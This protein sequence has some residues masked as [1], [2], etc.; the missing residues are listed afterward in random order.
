MGDR[1]AFLVAASLALSVLLSVPSAAQPAAMV[2]DIATSG[3]NR[4]VPFFPPT[5]VRWG[6]SLFFFAD[7]GVHGQELWASDGTAEGTRMVLDICPG[8]CLSGFSSP[9]TVHDGALYF[10]ANDGLHGRELWR[11]D[12]TADGT[13]MV[14]DGVPGTASSSPE[15]LT[16]CGSALLFVAGDPEHGRELWASDGTA[17]GT[18]LLADI[19]PAGSSRPGGF[20]VWNGVAYFSADDG[21]HGR[22]PWRT[23]GTAAGTWMVRDIHAGFAG[24]VS[25]DLSYVDDFYL[26]AAL[27]GALLFAAD[28][29]VHGTELW[30]SDGTEGGTELV[31][32]LVPG[33]SSDSSSPNELTRLGDAVYFAAD[34]SLGRELWASDGTASGTHLVRD[35]APGAASARPFRFVVAGDRLFFAATTDALG[36]ELWTSDGTSAGTVLVEDLAPGPDGGLALSAVGGLNAFGDRVLMTARDP[37]HGKEPWVS[38]GTPGGTFRLADL[39]AGAAGAFDG[40]FHGLITGVLTG[41]AYFFGFSDTVG[42][43]LWRTDGTVAGT[44][45]VED[46][47]TQQS[48]VPDLDFLHWTELAS[49]GGQIFLR[50]DDAVHGAQLWRIDGTAAGTVRLTDLPANSITD[51]PYRLTSLGDQL[52]FTA[53]GSADHG[54]LWSSDGTVAGTAPV[55]PD[56][57]PSRPRDPTELTPFAG[58]VF[59]NA[60]DPSGNGALWRSD[61]TE[62]GTAPYLAPEAQDLEP[63][64]NALFLGRRTGLWKTHGTSGGFEVQLADVEVNDLHGAS[65]LLFFAGRD[66]ATGAELWASDGTP[67]G[68][69]RVLDLRAGPEGSIS[70]YPFEHSTVPT[71]RPPFGDDGPQ[72]AT[73]PS[74]DEAFFLADDGIH[75]T[76]LWRSDGTADGTFLLRDIAAGERS[77]IPRYLTIVRGIAYFVADDGIHGAELWRSDGTSDGTILLADIEPGERSSLPASLHEIFGHLIF[78][79]W[80][81]DDGRELWLS[82]G[83]PERTRRLQDINPG[84]GSSTPDQFTLASGRL[85]FTATDGTHGFEPWALP[86]TPPRIEAA[87]SV[88]GDSSQGGVVVYTLVLTNLGTFAQL[89]NPGAEVVD[90]LPPGLSVLAVHADGGSVT[91]DPPPLPGP[92][93]GSRAAPRAGGS[94]TEVTW[95]GS[96]PGE[97]AVV[98]TIEAR[99]DSMLPLGAT[100]A[101]QA[102]VH[103]DGDGS[104]DNET[105]APSDDPGTSAPADPTLLVVGGDSVLAIPELS[106][107]GLLIFGLLLLSAGLSALRP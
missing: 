25:F 48:S 106:L 73:V 35:I 7:D 28:D 12:G 29:G 60:T 90:V 53:E 26:P 83:A 92:L 107:P 89:D 20:V 6:N 18:S 24:S 57:S 30:R 94:E 55:V 8:D 71:D 2:A 41:R 13:R 74:R 69:H 75:G 32:D 99:I 86:A 105:S 103:F 11:S 81:L 40:I 64:G 17:A 36:T 79:A 98:I 65:S 52:L 15:W 4:P 39:N 78:S 3:V 77:S 37:A 87:M 67:S 96:I 100:L 56:G 76:E 102:T 38:D 49:A 43:E 44:S 31:V 70:S 63:L 34:S 101:N 61:G 84:T 104:G 14:L 95:N 46:I 16:S 47:D 88:A 10:V 82:D 66:D 21:V 9:I 50:A 51:L 72:I 42:S 27:D 19:D 58:A 85:Y 59:F 91:V 80:R 93:S 5:P 97:G 23:D 1:Q 45:L 62:P 33:T 22:E 54:A 68:T